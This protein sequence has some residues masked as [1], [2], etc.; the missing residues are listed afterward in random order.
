MQ[1]I[2]SST[3]VMI[4]ESVNFGF[5]VVA[6][7]KEKGVYSWVTRFLNNMVFLRNLNLGAL[8]AFLHVLSLFM[9]RF[10]I[11]GSAAY[12]IF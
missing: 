3:V 7:I 12:V 8:N 2:N 1:V 9:G 10:I 6:N 11:F 4:I 5:I